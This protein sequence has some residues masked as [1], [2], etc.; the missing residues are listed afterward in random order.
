MLYSRCVRPLVSSAGSCGRDRR[1][2]QRCCA[3]VLLRTAPAARPPRPPA[4]H[5]SREANAFYTPGPCMQNSRL[6]LPMDCRQRGIPTRRCFF[7]NGGRVADAWLMRCGVT[8]PDERGRAAA[9][10][11]VASIPC[12]LH[13]ALQPSFLPAQRQGQRPR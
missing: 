10:S 4:L 1:R 7:Q 13:A 11:E 8:Q 3:R 5:P 6:R 2:G 12:F 9:G